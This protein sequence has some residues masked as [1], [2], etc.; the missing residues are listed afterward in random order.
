MKPTLFL[1]VVLA[2][3]AL[4]CGDGGRLAVS[5]R[6]TLDGQPLEDGAITFIPVEGNRG[7]AA[8]GAIQ[9]GEFQIDAKDGPV[10]GKNR[11]EIRGSRHTGR[12]IPDPRMPQSK[13]EETIPI[14]Q[15]YNE[16][17][18]IVRDLV[19]GSSDLLFELN[20]K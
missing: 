3:L 9:D 10:L 12:L 15:R 14:P 5:G 2:A 16:K 20:S 19:P 7:P 1:G 8:G 11:I 13:I 18:E 4:G 17:S 6:V